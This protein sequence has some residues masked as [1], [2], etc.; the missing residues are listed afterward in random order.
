M[1]LDETEEMPL[2]I[3]VSPLWFTKLEESARVTLN[4][5]AADETDA[6]ASACSK[7]REAALSSLPVENNSKFR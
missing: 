2:G 7:S 5:S 1:L 3:D 6:A 4:D